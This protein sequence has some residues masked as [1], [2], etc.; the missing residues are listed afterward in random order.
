[1]LRVLNS[2]S[3]GGGADPPLYTF[4]ILILIEFFLMYTDD[5]LTNFSLFL[6][7]FLI[8]L[9]SFETVLIWSQV[10]SKQK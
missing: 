5:K 10:K 8:S 6:D 1:M 2:K 7:F 9:E 4:F 3:F